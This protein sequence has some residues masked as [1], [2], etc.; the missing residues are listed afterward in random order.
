MSTENE[1]IPRPVPP[2]PPPGDTDVPLIDHL[3]ELRWRILTCLGTFL[4]LFLVAWWQS[5]RLVALALVPL[6]QNFPDLRLAA[7]E[8][9]EAFFTT[10]KLAAIAALIGT[11][12]VIVW[13]AWRFVDPALREGERFWSR[14]LLLPAMFL[15]ILGCLFCYTIALPAALKILL[16][17]S[18]FLV[19]TISYGGFIEFEV[20]FLIIM[21]VIFE[22]PLLL[23][24]L[25]VTGLFPVEKVREHRRLAI[26]IAFIVGG[27]LSPPDVV[28]QF[29]VSVPIVFLLEAGIWLAVLIRRFREPGNADETNDSSSG[30]DGV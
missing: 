23:V 8:V 10:I 13:Q 6:R 12:P 4:L 24:F 9:T 1:I 2:Q 20:M 29:L 3:A 21:G 11:L 25:D 19:P 5:D 16:Q 15:F 28:S 26:V 17:A 27:I 7:L 14:L 18:D 30:G 22:L